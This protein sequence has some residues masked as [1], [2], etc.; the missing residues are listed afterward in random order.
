MAILHISPDLA[1]AVPA[2][3]A[4][5]N[6]WRAYRKTDSVIVFVHG[7]LS[8]ALACWYNKS[9]GIYWPDMVAGDKSFDNSSIFLGGYYTAFDSTDFGLDDCAEH[10]HSALARPDPDGTRAV[11]DHSRLIFVCHSLGG[12]VTRYMLANWQSEFYNKKIGLLLIAS[13][14]IGSR[15]ANILG[16]P[17]SM[18]RHEIGRQLA[19][20]SDALDQ[21][22]RQFS[23]LK[24]NRVLTNLIGKELCEHRFMVYH[25]WLGPLS[26]WWFP[27]IVSEESA[28]RYWPPSVKIP[29]T[30][31]STI[32]KPDSLRHDSHLRLR[33][34]YVEAEKDLP[35]VSAQSPPV[36][37]VSASTPAPMP[38]ESPAPDSSEAVFE[39]SRLTWEVTINEDGD[40]PNELTLDGITRARSGEE[41]VFPMTPT[42][43]QSG[44]T[45]RF[46]IDAEQSSPYVRLRE[47][48]IRSRLIRQTAVFGV[49]PTPE[50]PQIV[51]LRS[52]D[53]NVYSMNSAEFQRKMTDK[54]DDLDYLQKSIRWESFGELTMI[55]HFP[56]AMRLRANAPVSLRAFHIVHREA[57]SGRV[58]VYDED[59]TVEAGRSFT[60]DAARRSAT[61]R[62]TKP[63]HWT[64][65]RIS[66]RLAPPGTPAPPPAQVAVADQHRRALL[67]IRP[68]FDGSSS[69]SAD[70]SA[71]KEKLLRALAMFGAQ[72][73]AEVNR[74]LKAVQADA[75]AAIDLAQLDLSLMAVDTVAE[76]AEHEVLRVVAGLNVIPAYWALELAVGDGIAGRAAKRVQPRKYCRSPEASLQNDAYL[77]FDGEVP[78]SQHCWLLSIPLHEECCGPNPYGVVNIGAFDRANSLLLNA[79]DENSIE[80]L[81]RYANSE[82]LKT[83]LAAAR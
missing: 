12:V 47:D 66:W 59:L 57:L 49:R 6:S 26:K 34:F 27:R 32:V 18:L 63:H 3:Q 22:D 73:V 54:A 78:A 58:D 38:A 76:P 81:N 67:S 75:N 50:K 82:F 2:L 61:L 80:V 14:S 64:A 45:S 7:V 71:K 43:V 30:N 83:V 60:Y 53:F 23:R 13:P 39:C 48:E 52:I 17:I 69:T 21:L 72:V 37:I 70:E 8:N 33:D 46:E 28:G 56:E 55:V 35:L 36:A 51:L 11:M 29:G 1:K 77:A 68:L 65:Y 74:C 41:S 4:D 44:H 15:Y 5:N 31:H 24:N 42:W 10:L 79:L 20:R 9:A 62:I 25:P 19:W 40:A 16:N